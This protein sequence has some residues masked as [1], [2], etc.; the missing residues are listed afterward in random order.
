MP[1]AFVIFISV[2]LK[3]YFFCWL[4]L[5]YMS[6][7]LKKVIPEPRAAFPRDMGS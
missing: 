2:V 7:T 6:G 1:D 5:L 3:G 4:G